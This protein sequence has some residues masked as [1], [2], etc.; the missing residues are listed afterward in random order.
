MN[1]CHLHFWSLLVFRKSWDPPNYHQQTS[2]FH[3]LFLLLITRNAPGQSASS[4]ITGTR[5]GYHLSVRGICSQGSPAVP[6]EVLCLPSTQSQRWAFWVLT[7]SKRVTKCQMLGP[8]CSCFT[9]Q[10]CPW[11]P[12]QL[13]TLALICQA[14]IICFSCCPSPTTPASPNQGKMGIQPFVVTIFSV[15]F[16]SGTL[17]FWEVL[18]ADILFRIKKISEH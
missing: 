13:G 12:L 4:A 3:Y 2:H 17:T 15:V 14:T 7:H 5:P 6:M 11:C 8:L 1:P 16:H 10:L 18:I 9:E